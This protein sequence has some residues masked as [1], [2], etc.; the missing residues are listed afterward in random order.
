V[1]ASALLIECYPWHDPHGTG[2]MALDALAM[3]TA[4]RRPD[5]HLVAL[6]RSSLTSARGLS[7]NR[8][9]LGPAAPSAPFLRS[10]AVAV[11]KALWR[12]CARR[13]RLQF[14][15]AACEIHALTL[16]KMSEEGS[17]SPERSWTMESDKRLSRKCSARACRPRMPSLNRQPI[18]AVIHRRR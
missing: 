16:T 10:A 6:D 3:E 7:G 15:S 18:N 14:A 5:G 8:A 1:G 13:L 9:L 4:I 17:A 11:V 2:E 12:L